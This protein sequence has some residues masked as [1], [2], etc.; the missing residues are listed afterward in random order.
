VISLMTTARHAGSAA[1]ALLE[2]AASILRTLDA[3][4]RLAPVD[5]GKM[6]AVAEMLAALS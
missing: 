5:R 2:R 6:D 4:A 1:R 3:E